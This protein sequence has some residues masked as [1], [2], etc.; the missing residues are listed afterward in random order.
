MMIVAR[1]AIS[2]RTMSLLEQPCCNMTSTLCSDQ[3]HL[4]TTLAGANNQKI[5]QP[6]RAG[7]GRLDKTIDLPIPD[8]ISLK[9]DVTHLPSIQRFELTVLPL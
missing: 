3:I 6:V 4:L 1:Y 5:E 2:L 9:I 7:Q 8:S